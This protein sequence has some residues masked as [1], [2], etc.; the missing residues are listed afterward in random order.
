MNTLCASV[1]KQYGVA[2]SNILIY[3]GDWHI[4]KNF[5]E[6]LMRVYFAPGL[7]EIAMNSGY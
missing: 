6:V 7:K 5:Q 1:K 4:L 2:L 3:P